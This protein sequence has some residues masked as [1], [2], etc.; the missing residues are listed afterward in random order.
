MT[1]TNSPHI[2]INSAVNFKELLLQVGCMTD[3][4]LSPIF[5]TIWPTFWLYMLSKYRGNPWEF[6]VSLDDIAFKE[7]INYFNKL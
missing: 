2:D 4:Q 1:T 3:E 6:V 7:F 5:K